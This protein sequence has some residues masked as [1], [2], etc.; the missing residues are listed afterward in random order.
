MATDRKPLSQK[1]P[2]LDNQL[3]RLFEEFLKND[4]QI[5]SR[6]DLIDRIWLGNEYVGRSAL[7]KNVW[8]LRRALKANPSLSH[9]YI[10]TIPKQ[11]YR[12]VVRRNKSIKKLFSRST[13]VSNITLALLSILFVFMFLYAS[14]T[15]NKDYI[16][17]P[18]DELEKL[19]A[20]LKGLDK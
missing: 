1:I 7:T 17:V 16:L 10:E 13:K 6:K 11:G 15:E 8:R 12:L 20:E 5:I 19:P 4:G 9:Y 18:S 14:T 2:K 3:S